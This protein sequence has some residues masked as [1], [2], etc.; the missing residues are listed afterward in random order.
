[1]LVCTSVERASGNA[2]ASSGCCRTS[3][4]CG[5]SSRRAGPRR[6]RVRARAKGPQLRDRSASDCFGQLKAA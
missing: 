3:R 1:M 6:E 4:S 2:T 5:T